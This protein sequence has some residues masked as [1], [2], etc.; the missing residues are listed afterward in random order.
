MCDCGQ[1]GK[2][3]PRCARRWLGLCAECHLS[4]EEEESSE[5]EAPRGSRPGP[6]RARGLRAGKETYT[7]EYHEY[8]LDYDSEDVYQLSKPWDSD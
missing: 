8:D 4:Y 1:C 2:R 3:I 7:S 6:S 5:E